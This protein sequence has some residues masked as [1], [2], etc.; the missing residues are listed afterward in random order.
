MQSLQ[1]ILDKVT[2]GKKIFGTSFAIKKDD[3]LW[4]GASGN[5]S[6]EQ[7][8]FIASTTKLFTT[9]I[10]FQLR[11]KGLLNLNDKI[12]KYL[13]QSILKNLHIY[14]GKDYSS[15]LEISHLLSHTS[16]LPDY[17]QGKSRKTNSL[18]D[19]LKSG[20][21]QYWSFEEAVE[22]AKTMR[23]VFM[24]NTR[25]KAHYSDTNFQLLGKIIENITGKS[26]S[27][28][29]HDFIFIPL[30]LNNTYL[31]QDVTDKNP[32]TLYYK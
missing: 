15:E 6:K 2:D 32:K 1:D 3:L 14:K 23:P 21:D 11:S 24:P 17:F 8:Y 29:C 31:Y 22:R 30:K 4:S 9:A 16:G 25:N 13:D 20:N 28:N 19:D 26:Y 18:E 27:T 7:I 5:M 12:S 10:I